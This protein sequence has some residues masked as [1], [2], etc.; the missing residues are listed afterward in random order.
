MAKE[1]PSYHTILMLRAFFS[2]RIQREKTADT[3]HDRSVPTVVC[4]EKNSIVYMK[5][6]LPYYRKLGIRHFI[7]IDD[8]STDGTKE[9]LQKQND[10][11]IYTAPKPYEYHRRGGWVLQVIQDCGRDRWYL[12]LDSDEFLSW[13]GMESSDIH[14]ILQLMER[15]GMGTIRALMLDMYPEHGFLDGKSDDEAFMEDYLWFDDGS[16]F[17]EETES[18]EIFGGMRW[19]TAGAKLRMDKYILFRPDKGYWPIMDHHVTGIHNSM[20]KNIYCVFRHYKFLPSQAEKYKYIVANKKSG[21][22]SFNEVQKYS[23]FLVGGSVMKQGLSVKWESSESLA[24]M[25]LVMTMPFD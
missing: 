23:K 4:M 11:T 13:R 8:H 14:S 5:K 16:S 7:M 1:K 19:R 6:L 2:D 24:A 21:Y 15:H 20:E 25:D 3:Y 18:G 17:S 9:Y 22:S 10:V 12:R